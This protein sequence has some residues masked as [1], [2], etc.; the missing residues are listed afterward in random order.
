MRLMFRSFKH[1][2][3]KVSIEAVKFTQNSQHPPWKVCISGVRWCTHVCLNMPQASTWKLVYERAE[4]N[5]EVAEF[6]TACIFI[7]HV[8]IVI[9]WTV[10][11]SLLNHNENMPYPIWK[12]CHTEFRN[13]SNNPRKTN[14]LCDTGRVGWS[15]INPEWFEIKF[16]Q[17]TGPYQYWAKWH[18]YYFF[19]VIYFL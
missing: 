1:K 14:G 8:F 16:F 3:R 7:R 9:Q 6:R 17:I 13:L 11:H 18:H 2:K 10:T 12:P 19:R 15:K 5:R 4:V